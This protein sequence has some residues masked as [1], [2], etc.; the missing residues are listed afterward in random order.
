MMYSMDTAPTDRPIL[1]KHWIWAYSPTIGH[2]AR[3]DR[4]TIS[5]CW[6]DTIASNIF[7]QSEGRWK[8]WLGGKRYESTEY[9]DPISWAPSPD[10]P[11]TVA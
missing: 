6:R 4:T 9:I 5:L 1:I 3:T 7:R 10:D 2:S 8:V 11:E